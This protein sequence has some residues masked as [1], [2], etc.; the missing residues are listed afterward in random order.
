MRPQC[1]AVTPIGLCRVLQ[2]GR[3]LWHCA[4]GR[5]SRVQGLG[6][7]YGRMEIA[8]GRGRQ[9]TVFADVDAVALAR[10]I[11]VLDG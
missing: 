6:G 1:N 4:A 9:I 2:V 3:K 10:V 7:L 8:L 5:Q 11:N